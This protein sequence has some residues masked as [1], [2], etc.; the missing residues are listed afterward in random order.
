M[1]KFDTGSIRRILKYMES[2]ETDESDYGEM[3]VDVN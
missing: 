3:F 2:L 1:D